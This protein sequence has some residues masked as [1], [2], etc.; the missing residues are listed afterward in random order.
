MTERLKVSPPDRWLRNRTG[1]GLGYGWC[2]CCG[3]SWHWK[4]HHS[5]PYCSHPGESDGPCKGMFPLCVE[6]WEKLTPAQ[7]LPYYEQIITA[8]R[9]DGFNN[10]SEAEAI[11]AAVLAGK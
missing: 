3:D 2:G 4:E 9:A 8:W 7:R 5:T 1:H 10:E 11:R 6:C